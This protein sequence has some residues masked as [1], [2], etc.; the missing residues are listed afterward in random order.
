MQSGVHS[1]TGRVAGPGHRRAVAQAVV[2]AQVPLVEDLALAGLAWGRLPPPVSAFTGDHPGAV[3]GSLSKLL[4]GGL[5]LGFVRAPQPVAARLARVKAT[6]DLGTSVVSQLLAE[7][8]LTHP[9]LA[10]ALGRRNV[11]L[12][13]RHDVLVAA[14]ADRLP[15]WRVAPPEGGLSLWVRLPA[16][17]AEALGQ[18]ALRHG[19][20]VATPSSLS[21][22]GDDEHVRLSFAAPPAVLERGVERLTAAWSE[23]RDR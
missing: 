2:G 18:V 17:R 14:L 12:R 13:H 10:D 15:G 3:V 19:V 1:P 6:H 23:L 20:A 11:E 8:W 7:A 4:W 22:A 16:P 21:V 9:V 5:R